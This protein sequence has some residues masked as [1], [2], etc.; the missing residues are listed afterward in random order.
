VKVVFEDEASNQKSVF[1]HTEG[2]VDYLKKIIT[3]RGARPA[4]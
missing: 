3:E 2:I 4:H 1:E